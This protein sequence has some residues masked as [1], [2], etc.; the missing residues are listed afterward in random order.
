ML[1][2]GCT[3]TLG[4]QVFNIPYGSFPHF[5]NFYAVLVHIRWI[6][7]LLV[8]NTVCLL[9][10]QLSTMSL[11]GGGASGMLC[12]SWLAGGRMLGQWWAGGDQNLGSW[13]GK[14][15]G[16]SSAN[17]CCQVCTTFTGGCILG[18]FYRPWS[19]WGRTF[20]PAAPVNE[21]HAAN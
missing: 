2:T 17:I 9:C 10:A 20:K 5:D 19:T 7:A 12:P 21:R 6:S 11:C 4:K 13:K 16:L 14:S 18:R 15:S 1:D 3:G 8:A